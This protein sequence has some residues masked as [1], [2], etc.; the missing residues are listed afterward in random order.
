VH[1]FSIKGAGFRL[2]YAAVL[3]DIVSCFEDARIS[4]D[5][6]SSGS[7]SGTGSKE[8]IMMAEMALQLFQG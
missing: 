2:T 6:R 8:D 5:F 7:S 3:F 1:E 4:G